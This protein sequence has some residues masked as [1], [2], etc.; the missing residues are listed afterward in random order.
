M[1]RAE[2]LATLCCPENHSAVKPASESLIKEINTAIRLRSLR[3]QGG[4]LLEQ[5]IT[6]GL[7]RADGEVVYP[8]IDD[9]PVLV[10]S[11]GI[12]LEQLGSKASKE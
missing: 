1:L 11:E 4:Q 5:P 3:N 6:G 7:V 2:I 10:H 8:I 12:L 9:I